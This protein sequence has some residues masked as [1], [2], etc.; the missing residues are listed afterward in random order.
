MKI[1]IGTP[2]Y[3]G[4][5][6]T[7]Y[8]SSVLDLVRHDLPVV[9]DNYQDS[10]ITR[11]RNSIVARFLADESF[12]HLFFIDADIGFTVEQFCH[13]VDSP[14]LITAGAYPFK[15]DFID[16]PVS[17]EQEMRKYV[18]NIVGEDLTI[19]PDGLIEVLDAATGFLCIKREAFDVLRNF[20][21]ELAYKND[22]L[23][24]PQENM[25]LFFDTMIENGRYLSE[26]YAFCRRW[27]NTGGKIWLDF[28]SKLTHTGP[29]T[30]NGD[31]QLWNAK[32]LEKQPSEK[33][34]ETFLNKVRCNRTRK[35]KRQS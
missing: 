1:L 31:L 15:M 30:F 25:W 6:C 12:T 3:N 11:A 5:V 13:L 10:L 27:Q 20:Y 14:H 26:D 8:M 4:N 28:N 18:V 21:P 17:H 19:P 9:V 23:G 32:L 16:G 22:V 2:A 24:G 7:T 34:I 29:K 35:K 33:P